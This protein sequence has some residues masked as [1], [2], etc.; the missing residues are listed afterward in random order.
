MG[1]RL[2][3][4][5]H[6]L[7]KEWGGYIRSLGNPYNSRNIL[8]RM[9]RE[10]VGAAHVYRSLALDEVEGEESEPEVLAFHRA[11]LR[12]PEVNRAVIFVL[13]V[14]QARIN[15][16]LLVLNQLHGLSKSRVYEVR[17]QSHAQIWGWIDAHLQQKAPEGCISGIS[18]C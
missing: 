1:D 11:F 10:G 16:R 9:M 12:L 5:V 7:A 17:G 3:E 8:D 2:I 14:P 4:W 15:E 18:V 13:Y 6:E